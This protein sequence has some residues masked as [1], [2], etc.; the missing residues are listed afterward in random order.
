MTATE[1]YVNMNNCFCKLR[2]AIYETDVVEKDENP[3]WEKN[4]EHALMV[5][6]GYLDYYKELNKT[7][8]HLKGTVDEQQSEEAHVAFSKEFLDRLAEE[9]TLPVSNM[10]PIPNKDGTVEMKKVTPQNLSNIKIPGTDIE[11]A[12]SIDKISQSCWKCGKAI[13]NM[14]NMVLIPNSDNK[15][16]ETYSCIVCKDCYNSFSPPPPLSHIK[17]SIT[18]TRPK[19]DSEEY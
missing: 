8:S 6:M 16:G 1:K 4:V 12:D 9:R 19:E 13:E 15:P 18:A 5:I 7:K 3:V 14:H 2:D 11:I 17:I 10:A